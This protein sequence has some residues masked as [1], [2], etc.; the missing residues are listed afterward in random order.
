LSYALCVASARVASVP[1]VDLV[2]GVVDGV[3]DF[4][5]S[6]LERAFFAPHERE[7]Q[8]RAGQ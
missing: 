8:D 3:I 7:R 6:L 5:A 2:A 1:A 4:L